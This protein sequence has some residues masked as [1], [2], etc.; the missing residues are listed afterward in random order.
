MWNT[1]GRQPKG[2]KPK[3]ANVKKGGQMNQRNS[4]FRQ[5]G[6]ILVRLGA[7]ALDLCVHKC[8]FMTCRE[9]GGEVSRLEKHVWDQ[10]VDGLRSRPGSSQ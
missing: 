4:F 10:K 1:G 9:V 3:Q 7:P 2:D 6:A 5:K 8:D